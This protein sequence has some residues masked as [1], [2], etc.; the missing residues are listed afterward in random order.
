MPPKAEGRGRATRAGTSAS[1]FIPARGSII[2]IDFDPQA[3]SEQ[4]RRRPAIVL[5]DSSYNMAV[6]L[7]LVCPIISQQK[8]YPF[9]IP[10]PSGLAAE[11]AILA[12]HLKSLDWRARNARHL[13]DAPAEVLETVLDVVADLLQM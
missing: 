7:C 3:G 8:G 6:G 9:E 11:G 4:A 1:P 5:T 12:D 13:C 10:L 2:D